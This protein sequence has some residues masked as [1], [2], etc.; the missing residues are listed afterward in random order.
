MQKILDGIANFITF[1]GS[2]NSNFVIHICK[3]EK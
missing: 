3:A 1:S 2:F